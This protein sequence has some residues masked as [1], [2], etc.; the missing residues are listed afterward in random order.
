M[1]RISVP[2]TNLF[3]SLVIGS[4]PIVLRWFYSCN[5]D[6]GDKHNVYLLC[7][8]DWKYITLSFPE[9]RLITNYFSIAAHNPD[10][11]PKFHLA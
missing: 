10:T 2:L 5:F 8:L 11:L 3:I 1:F 6:V 9:N 7:L 4:V